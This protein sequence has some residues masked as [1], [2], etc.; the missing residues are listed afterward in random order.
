MSPSPTCIFRQSLNIACCPGK[1]KEKKQ[2][3]TTAVL[4]VED[5]PVAELLLGRAGRS[6]VVEVNK[7]W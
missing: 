7:L 4:P 1:S 6:V 3:K 2:I 5:V